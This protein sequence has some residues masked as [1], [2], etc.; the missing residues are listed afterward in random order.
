MDSPK[1]FISPELVRRKMFSNSRQVCLPLHSIKLRFHLYVYVCI[2]VSHQD[3]LEEMKCFHS[4]VCVCVIHVDRNSDGL[5]YVNAH[6]ITCIFN[7]TYYTTHNEQMEA[8]LKSDN[9]NKTTPSSHTTVI[10]M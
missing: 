1:V 6:L 7:K 3:R 8:E 9:S 5:G 2:S 10:Y 4:Y